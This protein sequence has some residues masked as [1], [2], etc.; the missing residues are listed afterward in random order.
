M[1][2]MCS[3]EDRPLNDDY[4]SDD[5]LLIH[6]PPFRNRLDQTVNYR[7]F[8]DRAHDLSLDNAALNDR[9]NDAALDYTTLDPRPFI[10]VFSLNDA[11]NGSMIKRVIIVQCIASTELGGGRIGCDHGSGRIGEGGYTTDGKCLHKRT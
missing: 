9:P 7:S 1:H 11:A 2:E 5:R 8:H 10:L 4:F 3:L 6:D